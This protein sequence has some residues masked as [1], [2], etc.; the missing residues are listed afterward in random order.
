MQRLYPFENILNFRD[1]GGYET[2]SGQKIKPGKLFRSA[3]FHRATSQDLAQISDLDIGLL[4]DLRYAPE[5]ARQPNKWP[6][7]ARTKVLA[8]EDIAGLRDKDIAPHEAFIKTDLRQAQDAR[9]YMMQ[10]YRSRPDDPGFEAIFSNTLRHMVDTGENIVI[11]CAAGKDRTG[12][13]AAIILSTLGVDLPMIMTDYMLTMEAVDIESFLEPAAT[14][15]S[16]RHEREYS[17]DALRPM[18]GVEPAYLES[19]LEAIGDMSRYVRDNLRLSETDIQALKA[20]YLV[21]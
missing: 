1:F 10:S 12:T 19:S 16:Q 2:L 20:H 11:H 4:V 3:N 13:L 15:M 7:A 18:F 5:R 17:P 6:E 9:N 8:F 14:M 21:S